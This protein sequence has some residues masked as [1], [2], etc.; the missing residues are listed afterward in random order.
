MPE[1][2][3]FTGSLANISAPKP[4]VRSDSVF[5]GPTPEDPAVH[6]GTQSQIPVGAEI[7]FLEGGG[8]RVVKKPQNNREKG[9][10]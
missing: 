7:E 4:G 9:Q 5:Q 2:T 8:Y 6:G 3:S 10:L 1:S